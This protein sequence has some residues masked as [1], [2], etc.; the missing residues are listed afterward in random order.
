MPQTVVHCPYTRDDVRAFA[1]AIG[2][3]SD[4]GV[5]P[6]FPIRLMTQAMTPFMGEL[7]A[8]VH[9]HDVKLVHASQGITILH[10]LPEQGPLTASLAAT[11]IPKDPSKDRRLTVTVDVSDAAGTTLATLKSGLMLLPALPTGGKPAGD[12][13]GPNPVVVRFDDA[14]LRAYAEASLDDNPIHTDPAAAR[15]LGLDRCVVQGMLTL[16]RVTSA[17]A[18]RYAGISIAAV[19]ALFLSPVLSGDSVRISIDEPTGGKSRY[20]VAR[21]DGT[22][23][24]AGSIRFAS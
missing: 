9:D 13:E 6:T 10:P 16:G 20:A 19:D 22:L 5:P 8:V 1:A 18:S 11:D 17:T 12:R 4:R 24:A 14:A 3:P 21:S 2:Y 23:V 7:D 15:A